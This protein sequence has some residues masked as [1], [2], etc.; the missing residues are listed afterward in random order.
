MRYFR[1]GTKLALAL[2]FLL[3]GV[4]GTDATPTRSAPPAFAT[5]VVVELTDGRA[6]AGDLIRQSDTLV[7]LM[8]TGRR[9]PFYDPRVEIPRDEIVAIRREGLSRS[10][11]PSIQRFGLSSRT[12][13]FRGSGEEGRSDYR[14]GAATK[15]YISG[16]TG[17]L[18]WDSNALVFFE[19]ELRNFAGRAATLRWGFNVRNGYGPHEL[20]PI[21]DIFVGAKHASRGAPGMSLG[22]GVMWDVPGFEELGLA[23]RRV[24]DVD[25]DLTYETFWLLGAGTPRARFWAQG[26]VEWIDRANFQAVW[27]RPELAFDVSGLLMPSRP[28]W[29]FLVAG[30]DHTY[31]WEDRPDN[32]LHL[33]GSTPSPG[34]NQLVKDSYRWIGL[35]IE[36]GGSRNAQRR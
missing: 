16:E 30:Y 32:L 8:R 31:G 12:E 28:D 19:P 11:R 1:M 22:V 25:P 6:I 18:H 7:V 33:A 23:V 4:A 20:G 10:A 21:R 35:E 26:F 9:G 13:S 27:L 15:G 5:R 17:H 3:V 2:A 34:E 36:I 14:F 24:P 29:L